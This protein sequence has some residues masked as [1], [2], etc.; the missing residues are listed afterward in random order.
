[1]NLSFIHNGDASVASYRYRASIPARELSASLNA[2]NA[3]WLVFAKPTPEDHFA[4]VDARA[5]GQRVIVDFCDDHFARFK[6]YAAMAKM[7]DAV[8]CPTKEMAKLIAG[9]TGVEATVIHD[10]YEYPLA[11]PHCGG[12]KTLWFGNAVNW[13]SLERVLPDLM[14]PLT[15]V[16][17]MPGMMPW[18]VETML[19]EFPRADIVILPATAHYKSCNRAVEAIRQGCF[20]VAEPHPSLSVFMTEGEPNIWVGEIKE[21]V[22]W[23]SNQQN[24]PEANARTLNAQSLVERWFTPKTLASAWRSLLETVKSRSTSEAARSAGRAGSASICATR[25]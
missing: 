19:R 12:S 7:A 23:A 6:H 9:Y 11:A 4:A 13:K 16:S 22:E 17:N 10:P 1:M 18:S 24:W 15:I 3:D 20:V 2:L 5:G 14:V 25:P 21:G 8:T